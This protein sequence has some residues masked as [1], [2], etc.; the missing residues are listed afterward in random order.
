MS[1]CRDCKPGQA[2]FIPEK[3]YIYQIEEYGGVKGEAAM[4]N[5]I[6]QRGPISCAV[7]DPQSLIDYTYGIYYDTTGRT[8]EDHEISVVGWGEE[9]GV[10]YW[11]VRNSWGS[12]W[13]EE[14][15]FKVVRGVNNIGIEQDCDWAVPKDTW[16]EGVMH[17]T[18]EEEQNDPN[19]DK[20][21]YE[22]PQP[23]FKATYTDNSTSFLDE[24][25]RP[26]RVK[27]AT[28]T[29]G[30]H[31][32][33]ARSW[34]IIPVNL[35]P[36]QVDWRDMNGRNYMSWNKNQHIPRYCGSCWAQGTTSALADRFNIMTGLKTPTPIGLNA[37]V[38]INCQAGGS[39]DGGDP[40]KVYEYAFE[41][42][43]PDSSCEQYTA[44]NLAERAC[45]DVDLC[46]DCVP[47]VPEAGDD[48]LD[49]CGAVPHTKY[50]VSEY[51][52]VVGAEQMKSELAQHGPIGC[53]I[54][55]TR[56]FEGYHGGI[57]SQELRFVHLNHE[58]SVV[59]YG[60]TEEG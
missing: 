10:K 37:Q 50:Y 7:A 43:I 12:H 60:V 36:K 39:C 27:K 48:G 59:G 57:Y 23:E 16:T 53:G 11:R 58:V 22:F 34:D 9:N 3:Y 13:G 40:A 24:Q 54:Q 20:T 41:F 4:M 52:S 26:C 47:P 2:C 31:E 6:Y 49:Q 14:G 17:T 5:E 1:Y 18:T 56:A 8:S 29:N 21:V 45:G 38:V 25:D 44:S 35:L 30:S 42:G 28:F 15:F 32:T 46:K 55:A 33:T 51:Y 19:N